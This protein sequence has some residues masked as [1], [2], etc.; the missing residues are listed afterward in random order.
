MP[1]AIP[2]RDLTKKKRERER[3]RETER[4]RDREIEMSMWIRKPLSGSKQCYFANGRTL[5]YRLY[6][7]FCVLASSAE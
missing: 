1:R 3:E 2:S 6:A 4:D 7:R 5:S